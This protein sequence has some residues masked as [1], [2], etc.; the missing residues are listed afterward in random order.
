MEVSKSQYGKFIIGKILKFCRK[1]RSLVV[2]SFYGKVRKLI[3][4]KDASVVI[5]ECYSQYANATQRTAL[6]QEFY[7]P[8]FS[9]FKSDEPKTLG[10]LLTEQPVKAP[11]ILKHLQQIIFSL[12]EKE[13]SNLQSQTIIHRAILDYFKAIKTINL[14]PKGLSEG[15][16]SK[17]NVNPAI[18]ELVE[19]LKDHLVH[20]LHTREGSQVAQLTVLHATPKQRKA[21]IKSCKTFVTKIA[22]EQYG[23]AVLM[24]VF[25][26]L[27]DTV[28]VSKSLL[29]ELFAESSLTDLLRDSYGV[30]VI[31][32]L[33]SGRNR[34]AIA[35]SVIDELTEM[36]ADR[37]LTCKKSDETKRAELR[38]YTLDNLAPAIC[39][40]KDFDVLVRCKVANVV[41]LELVR[42]GALGLLD[43]IFSLVGG[44]ATDSAEGQKS[45]NAVQNMRDAT[46]KAK[47][48]E[49]GI[50]I[51]EPVLS[52]R[53]SSLFL[54][55]MIL[56]SNDAAEGIFKAIMPTLMSVI[57]ACSE[58]PNT[59][60]G[61]GYI[62][63]AL[64]EKSQD[65]L[66]K[67][68]AA[69]KEN[70]ETFAECEKKV[71]LWRKGADK[72]IKETAIEKLMTILKK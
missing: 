50:E 14:E 72:E 5:E 42:L 7:G 3:K 43:C 10:Q 53:N 41:L 12:L 27:D 28:L 57:Q 60:L 62:M 38:A 68:K 59:T 48:K 52:N 36:D 34:K 65:M 33:L 1:Y 35:G 46:V 8:E 21:I 6:M 67:V 24:S 29:S 20:I 69:I 71:S 40:S 56:C 4:N 55:K 47:L 66:N 13:Q 26:C 51:D 45:F 2:T 37:S 64:C 15:T 54:K 23:S 19:L 63:L 49:S 22:C 16:E 17:A 61:A 30:K 31:M 18:T 32:F 11:S 58:S 39:A 44:R 70:Q 9:V 25:E